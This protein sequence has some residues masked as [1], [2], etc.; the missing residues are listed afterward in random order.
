M[1]HSTEE[2]DYLREAIR[3]D[4]WYELVIDG[5][6][7]WG[8]LGITG[9]NP[10]NG[11]PEEYIFTHKHFEIAYNGKNIV[12]VTLN[13]TEP[14]LLSDFILKKKKYGLSMEMTY[15]ISWKKTDTL[16]NE[17]VNNFFEPLFFEHQGHWLALTNSLMLSLFLTGIV[18]II[19]THTRQNDV[20]SLSDFEENEGVIQIKNRKKSRRQK[21]HHKKSHKIDPEEEE[22]NVNE[23]EIIENV[24]EN[25]NKIENV[26]NTDEIKI[27]NGHTY[28]NNINK[29]K[30]CSKDVFRAPQ[31]GTFFSS[32]I[33]TG[34]QF[35]ATLF[36]IC[37]YG[38]LSSE[39]YF[40]IGDFAECSIYFYAAMSNIGGIISCWCYRQHHSQQGWARACIFTVFLFPCL[41]CILWL[42]H[43]FSSKIVNSSMAAPFGTHFT[44]FIIWVFLIIPFTFI[45][46]VFANAMIKK[47]SKNSKKSQ[48]INSSP[49]DTKKV[50][51][52]NK[53]YVMITIFIGSAVIF[54]SIISELYF[55][56]SS[57]WNYKFYYTFEYL[58]FT[59]F[60]L[61]I[62]SGTT[63][64]IV[65][66]RCLCMGEHR[67]HWVAFMTG[68]GTGACTV[69][70]SVAYFVRYASWSMFFGEVFGMITVVVGVAVGLLCAF[71][72]YVFS[73]FF[74]RKLYNTE[75]S[76]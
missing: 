33:G 5:L 70:Y 65:V 27:E 51:I 6:P 75:K 56:F 50:K 47:Y 26:N 31:Y 71:S 42:V 36:L 11:E 24:N 19:F 44:L 64:V 22:E 23:N 29:W 34:A 52:A 15:S 57:I 2:I 53:Y 68:A 16:P 55:V 61:V 66:Y 1:R 38:I 72:G 32:L 35:L 8:A 73:L 7:L 48:N 25:D 58:F 4:F 46:S 14:K 59:I 21:R 69:A 67:W 41:F 28:E 13:T 37:G 3:N 20:K 39:K 18:I 76:E 12:G 43:S 60:C 54:A 62:I 17:R 30:E 9:T 63:S 45:G 40:Y 49:V 74:V 10:D